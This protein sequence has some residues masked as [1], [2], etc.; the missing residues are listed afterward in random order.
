MT[1]LPHIF[2]DNFTHG[3]IVTYPLIILK[4]HINPSIHQA[5][6]GCNHN[7]TQSDPDKIILQHSVHKESIQPFNNRF[8]FILN[9]NEGNNSIKITSCGCTI[10]INLIYMPRETKYIVCPL[11]IICEEHDGTFQAPDDQDN[12]SESACKRINLITRMLQSVTA[13]KLYEKTLFRKTFHLEDECQIFRSKLLYLEATK[14][15]EKQLWE[16]IAREIMM[17]EIGSETKKY[18]GF[19]SCTRYCGEKYQESLRTHEDLV[20]ITEAYVALGGGGLALFGSASIYTWPEHFEEIVERFEDQRLIDKSCFLDD[21]CYRGTIGA[22][23][24]TSLGSV[25][26]ELCHTFDL[27]HSSSGIMARGFDN[28]YKVFTS[29]YDKDHKI[30]LQYH[31]TIEFKESLEPKLLSERLKNK[32]KEYQI[33][34]SR[35]TERDADDTF[36]TKSCAWILNYHRWLNDFKENSNYILKFDADSKAFTS[37]TGL[38]VVEI[39]KFSDELILEDWVFEGKILKYSFQIPQEIELSDCLIFAEDNVGNILKYDCRK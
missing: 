4:G 22:C 28:I 26:H 20:N 14:M 9:L 19:L 32:P 7:E 37:T 11:Y 12:S 25:L 1:H 23:F 10:E 8:K 24:S 13:E 18:L 15:D 38:R 34:G 6:D 5:I 30:S 33:T 35:K 36:W 29:H 2:I 21:S 27:G 16:F 17:S 31:E 3:E 39:R